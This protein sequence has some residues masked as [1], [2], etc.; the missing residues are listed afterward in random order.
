MTSALLLG[1]GGQ[2]GQA[3]SR[4]ASRDGLALVTLDRRQLDITDR[5]SVLRTIEH[6]A[7]STV[8][9]AAAYTAVDR[10][11]DDRDAAFAVNE[12]GA[13]HVAEACANLGVPLFH[14]STDYVFDGNKPA[15]YREDDPTAPINVY[16]ES[17]LAGE[18]AVRQSCPRR[19]V[20][21]RTSWLYGVQGRNFVSTMLRLGSSRDE[22]RVVDDQFGNPT[23]A[24]DL[25]GAM[26]RLMERHQSG[27]WPSCG[28]GT[29]HCAGQGTTTWCGF[30]RLVFDLAKP[31][32][33]RHP[34]VL[35]IRSADYPTQAT[36]PPNSALDCSRLHQVHGITLR[37]W[38]A[39]LGEALGEML[40]QP[41]E[42]DGAKTRNGHVTQ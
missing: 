38:R 19:H 9:N 31:S 16:G 25:A 36:R 11:E 17:K 37:D 2:L 3:L 34:K 13:A 14:V 1:A 24:G 30:A 28:F 29:F 39:A 41:G 42:P 15:P 23:F 27:Y 8:L 12:Q 5:D 10:A 20:I 32:L 26:L 18:E 35:A 4:Q 40:R 7:P 6:C 22:L 33:A 21:L